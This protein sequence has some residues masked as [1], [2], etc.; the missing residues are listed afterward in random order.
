MSFYT[1]PGAGN[2]TARSVAVARTGSAVFVTGSSLG[3]SGIFD[4][5]TV[6]YDAATGARLWASRYTGGGRRGRLGRGGGRR[7]GRP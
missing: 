3:A 4:Y 2:D 1:G 6:G 5:A 7:P